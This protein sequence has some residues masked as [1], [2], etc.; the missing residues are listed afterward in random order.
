M[1]KKSFILDERDLQDFWSKLGVKWGSSFRIFLYIMY[2]QFDL[3]PVCRM[4]RLKC[5][6]FVTNTCLLISCHLQTSAG[7]I[8]HTI[9][10]KTVIFHI[11]IGFHGFYFNNNHEY[12]WIVVTFLTRMYTVVKE[13]HLHVSWLHDW[14]LFEDEHLQLWDINIIN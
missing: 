14:D 13:L 7:W 3:A 6:A 2:R 5:A 9:F 8:A 4:R 10:S 12:G 11:N 1:W